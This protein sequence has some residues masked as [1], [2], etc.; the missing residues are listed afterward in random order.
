[1]RNRGV[2]KK[3]KNAVYMSNPFAVSELRGKLEYES[4]ELSTTIE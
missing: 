4:S 3:K 1:M 2:N